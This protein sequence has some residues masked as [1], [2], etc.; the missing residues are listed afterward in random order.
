MFHVRIH[1]ESCG[2]RHTYLSSSF[3]VTI[4]TLFSLLRTSPGARSF[5]TEGKV[6]VSS[7]MRCHPGHR[8]WTLTGVCRAGGSGRERP[9][10]QRQGCPRAPW[11]GLFRHDPVE[12]RDPAGRLDDRAPVTSKL[13]LRESGGLYV[14]AFP[15]HCCCGLSFIHFNS[16][17][18]SFCVADTCRNGWRRIRDRGRT[19]PDPS[20]S[21][22]P[23]S[24]SAR[25]QG[26]VLALRISLLP[27]TS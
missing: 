25:D 1:T 3:T 16:H 24:A 8:R 5:T 15:S 17:V 2:Y 23:G 4:F 7:F 9:H 22:G 14:R 18:V 27:R 11:S 26:P 20:R 10:H 21:R 13:A 12:G 6:H 19:D